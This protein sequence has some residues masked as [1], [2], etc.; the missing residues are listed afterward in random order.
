MSE[1]ERQKVV[2]IAK[3]WLGTP[4]RHNAQIKGAGADCATFIAEVFFEAGLVERFEIERYSPQW[5]LHRNTEK[6][7]SRVLE[8]SHE[9]KEPKPG[10]IVLWKIGRVF[11]HGAIVIK[12]PMIIHEFLGIGCVIDDAS[13][14]VW[15]T[16]IGERT[17]EQGKQRPMLFFSHWED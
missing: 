13:K 10:D 17:T 4:Y 16:K 1:I 11:S 9:V 14:A 2:E 7:M 5:H 8:Y 6:Y 12:W 15:L 3:S